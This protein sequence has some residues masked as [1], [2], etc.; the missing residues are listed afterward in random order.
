MAKLSI[1]AAVKVY[2]VS[3]PTLQKHLK[4]GKISGEKVAGKGWQIDTAELGRVYAARVA[5]GDNAFPP[6]LPPVVRDLETDLKAEIETLK[7]DLAIAEALAE[8]RARLL[9]QSMKLLQGPKV[10]WWHKLR[11]KGQ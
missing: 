10:S 9:D 7:R 1:S 4:S 3:R 5:K 6:D 2:D 11:R 8:E